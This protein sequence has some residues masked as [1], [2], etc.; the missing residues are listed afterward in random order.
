MDNEANPYLEQMKGHNNHENDM[1]QAKRDRGVVALGL[2]IVLV[3]SAYGNIYLMR[4]VKEVHHIIAVDDHGRPVSTLLR[5]TDEVPP[6]D[7]LKQVMIRQY[8]AEW[9]ANFRARPMDKSFLAIGLNTARQHTAGPAWAKFNTAYAEEKP[10]ERI[11]KERVEVEAKGQPIRLTPTRWQAEWWEKITNQN[12]NATRKEEF[13][14]WVQLAEKAEWATSDNP[15]G[16]RII[17][18]GIQ[19]ISTPKE[20]L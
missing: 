9:V 4:Q 16:M 10:W 6:E 8:V 13:V 1:Q 18:W 17:D 5:R 20:G 7:P 19:E 3:G 14:G 15:F 11:E 12:G 2:F